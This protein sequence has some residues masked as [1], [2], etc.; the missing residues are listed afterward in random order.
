LQ[1]GSPSAN[2]SINGSVNGNKFSPNGHNEE[3]SIGSA[4]SLARRQS[5]WD[6]DLLSGKLNLAMCARARATCFTYRVCLPL[7]IEGEETDEEWTP[8]Q[9]F[10]AANNLTSIQPI[11]ESEQIDLEAL[12][13]LTDMDIAALKLPLGPRRKLTNAIA[14]RK[15]ALNTPENVIKDSRL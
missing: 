3:I 15:K 10:L 4:G 8:L 9:R 7:L 14:N 2:G 12:M 1:N 5:L 13:L 6:D 11:L